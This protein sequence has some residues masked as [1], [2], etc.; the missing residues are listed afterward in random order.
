MEEGD[1]WTNLFFSGSRPNT[2]NAN[3]LEGQKFRPFCAEDDNWELGSKVDISRVPGAN[4]I[5]VFWLRIKGRRKYV[6]KVVSRGNHQTRAPIN[7]ILVPLL[8]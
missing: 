8:F 7:P 1:T 4:S 5:Q 3:E 6:G 2:L